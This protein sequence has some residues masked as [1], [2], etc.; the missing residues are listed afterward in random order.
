M[1]NVATAA[2]RN[3]MKTKG[4]SIELLAQKTGAKPSHIK[5]IVS[6]QQD[7]VNERLILKIAKV[8]DIHNGFIRTANSRK[9]IDRLFGGDDLTF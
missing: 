4:I 8:L 9:T 1:P 7:V 6:G 2:I 3:H 5:K